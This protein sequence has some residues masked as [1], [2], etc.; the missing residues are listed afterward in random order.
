MTEDDCRCRGGV[1]QNAAQLSGCTAGHG[2]LAGRCQTGEAFGMPLQGHTAAVQSLAISPLAD[3]HRI[4]SRAEVST[5]EVWDADA[6]KLFALLKRY[7]S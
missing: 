2:L 3:G 4:V 7:I 5:I 6:H 1:C